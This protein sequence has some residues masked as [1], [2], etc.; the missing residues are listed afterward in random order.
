MHTSNLCSRESVLGMQNHSVR[1]QCLNCRTFGSPAVSRSPL[2]TPEPQSPAQPRGCA[3]TKLLPVARLLAAEVATVRACSSGQSG[4]ACSGDED[5][6]TLRPR[7]R[8]QA[9]GHRTALSGTL[10]T[11]S[12]GSQTWDGGLRPGRPLLPQPKPASS[13][14]W[15]PSSNRT[16]RPLGAEG[17]Q[18]SH[19]SE[20]SPESG[21]P[22]H[23][24]PPHSHC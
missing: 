16:G 17:K 7:S 19:A 5:T 1:K 3:R 12:E 23:T 13:S 10:G 18:T 15:G 22:P 9:H 6:L 24:H 21:T 11:V 20:D 14:L 2:T 8:T 4:M